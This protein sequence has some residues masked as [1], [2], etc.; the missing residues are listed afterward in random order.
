MS[1]QQSADIIGRI[2]EVKKELEEKI[3][4]NLE[5]INIATS[6]MA[7]ILDVQV[8]PNTS[9]RFSTRLNDI[10][11]RLDD[12]EDSEDEEDEEDEDDDESIVAAATEAPRARLKY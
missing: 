1:N 7:D 6:H 10:E 4:E 9:E 3:E 2:E 12:L 8:N 5:T 11:R